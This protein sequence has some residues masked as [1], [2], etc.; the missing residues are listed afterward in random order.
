MKVAFNRNSFLS[1]LC[2]GEGHYNGVL[3]V[4]NFLSHLCGGEDIVS[5]VEV[6]GEGA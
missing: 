3:T 5:V 2:G 1:H 4:A 6:E